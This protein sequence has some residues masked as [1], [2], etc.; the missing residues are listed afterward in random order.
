MKCNLS[1]IA[2]GVCLS[3]LIAHDASAVSLGKGFDLDIELTAVSDYRY[4]GISQNQRNPALQAG[5]ALASPIGLHVGIWGS[6]VDYGRGVNTRREQDYYLGWFIPIT[7][8]LSIDVGLLKYEYP[9][10]SELNQTSTYGVVKYKGL[11]LTYQYT[12]DRDG[13]Q[14]GSYA[15]VGYTYT[16]NDSTR[17]KARYGVI[18]AKDQVFYSAS[19]ETRSRYHEWEAGVEKDLRGMTWKASYVDTDLSKMEC[20]NFQGY[21]NLCSGNVVVSVSKHF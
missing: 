15:T 13:N 11:E 7:D 20:Y 10:S 1:S 2:A 21:D 4:M 6:S 16:V 9:R 14:S 17:F 12:G 18:D 19:G 5:L 8:E 3:F